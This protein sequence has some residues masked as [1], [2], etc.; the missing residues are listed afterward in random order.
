MFRGGILIDRVQV[1]GYLTPPHLRFGYAQHPTEEGTQLVLVALW[2]WIG[3]D[4]GGEASMNKKRRRDQSVT[5]GMVPKD[6]PRQGDAACR[7]PR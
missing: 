4:G 1:S 6:I 5:S 7:S 3:H 2:L